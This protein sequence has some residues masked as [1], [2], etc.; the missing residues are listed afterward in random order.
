MDYFKSHAVGFA[1][2]RPNGFKID[3]SL[4]SL[5]SFLKSKLI[6]E[7]NLIPKNYI[8]KGRFSLIAST[9]NKLKVNHSF[10]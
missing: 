9:Y 5:N 10:S 3:F 6:K 2:L 1:V 8:F 7:K 4:L